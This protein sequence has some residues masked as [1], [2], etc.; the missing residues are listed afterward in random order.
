MSNILFTGVMSALVTPFG[1]DGKVKK[2]AV[3]KMIDW[4]LSEGLKG[5]YICG[6][7]GEGPALK[8]S[9]RMEMLETAAAAAKGRGVVIAHIGAP[10]IW[11]AMELTKHA[12]KT[13]VS[14]IS[15]LAPTYSY[16][17]SED[18]LFDYYKRIAD[19]TDLPVLV[20]ATAAMGVP[21]FPRLMAKLIT[22]PNVVGVKFTIRDYFELRK[23]KEVNGGDINLINGPD[24]TCSAGS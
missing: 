15:S 2:T 5:F 16:K 23:T 13:R 1:P 21:N 17:Y 18:E 7:T 10:N 4:Q 24:E 19:S 14:A 12:T 20:Y 11:D 9:T 3:E 8:P 6:S 22:I